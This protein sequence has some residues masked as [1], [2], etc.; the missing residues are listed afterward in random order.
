MLSSYSPPGLGLGVFC[1][2]MFNVMLAGVTG[3]SD[4]DRQRTVASSG[5]DDWQV[6][7]RG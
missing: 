1:W 6:S 4:L 2:Q 5:I 3:G 7:D